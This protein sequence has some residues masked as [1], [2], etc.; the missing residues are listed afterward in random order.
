M[1]DKRIDGRTSS[2]VNAWDLMAAA[3]LLRN[4]AISNGSEVPDLHDTYLDEATIYVQLANCAPEVTLA[5][6]DYMV[7]R[8]ERLKA[9][10]DEKAHTT[11]SA[12]EDIIAGSGMMPEKKEDDQKPCGETSPN[13]GGDECSGGTD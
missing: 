1:T 2:W 12:F 11:R 4:A 8:F 6:W 10:D 3:A 9:A 7:E 13:E 5:A